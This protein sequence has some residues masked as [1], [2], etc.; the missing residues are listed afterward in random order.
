M[1]ARV[2]TDPCLT[3]T[4][5]TSTRQQRTQ[6]VNFEIVDSVLEFELPAPLSPQKGPLTSLVPGHRQQASVPTP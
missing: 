5:P 2:M 4:A 3:R 6:H 1:L